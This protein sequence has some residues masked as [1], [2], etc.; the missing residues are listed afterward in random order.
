M[1]GFQSGQRQHEVRFALLS[2]T[3]VCNVNEFEAGSSA[4]IAVNSLLWHVLY[5]SIGVA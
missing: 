1:M 3:K 4:V 5:S 2:L